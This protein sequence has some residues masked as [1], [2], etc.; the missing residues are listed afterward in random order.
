M[1]RGCWPRTTWRVGCEHSHHQVKVNAKKEIEPV[2]G[3][4]RFQELSR[5]GLLRIALATM[6]PSKK[7]VTIAEAKLLVFLRTEIDRAV[8]GTVGISTDTCENRLIPS[9]RAV[10]LRS[11]SLL[12]ELR[13]APGNHL[14]QPPTSPKSWWIT[15]M[16]HSPKLEHRGHSLT[17]LASTSLARCLPPFYRLVLIRQIVPFISTNA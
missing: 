14:R 6:H 4:K 3:K 10:S 17:A 15:F 2:K 1:S 13:I 16:A 12:T 5:N 11:D 9:R 8:C 7:A